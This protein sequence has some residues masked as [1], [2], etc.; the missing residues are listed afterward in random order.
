MIPTLPHPRLVL[1][2]RSHSTRQSLLSRIRGE[3]IEM[4]CLRLTRDQAR[5]LFG[6]RPDVCDRVLA[7]L[8]EEGA[9]AC[10]TDG[11]YSATEGRNVL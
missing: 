1:D 3:F 11:R 5:R 7:T 6:L 9:L 10:G 4:P 8:V 2:R